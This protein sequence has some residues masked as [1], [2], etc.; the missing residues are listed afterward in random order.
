[1]AVADNQKFQVED[2][3]AQVWPSVRA[4]LVAQCARVAG[5][6]LNLPWTIPAPD[7]GEE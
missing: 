4:D 1:M 5:Q 2:L 7:Q 6:T 3:L